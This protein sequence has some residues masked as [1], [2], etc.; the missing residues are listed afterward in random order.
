MPAGQKV[1][2]AYIEVRPYLNDQ[3]FRQ[4]V[5]KS[6]DRSEKAWEASA[7][8]M[9]E[10]LT[11]EYNKAAGKMVD[12]NK[13]ALNKIDR[14]I[15]QHNAKQIS[16]NKSVLDKQERNHEASLSRRLKLERAA[17]NQVDRIRARKTSPLT[18]GKDKDR[19]PRPGS[20]A[21]AAAKSFTGGL[22]QNLLSIMPGQLEKIFASPK[23]AAV[24]VT[25]A[26]VIGAVLTDGLV[27]AIGAGMVTAGV[28]GAA[29]FL[30]KTNPAF[31][32]A[33]NAIGE[34]FVTTLKAKLDSL[35]PLLAGVM[36]SGGKAINSIIAS[37]DLGP[38]E[39]VA[40]QFSEFFQQASPVV[41]DLVNTF[42]QLGE[43]VMPTIL[44]GTMDLLGAFQTL[45]T[46][47]M[48][49][50]DAIKAVVDG[51]FDMVEGVVYVASALVELTGVLKTAV[52]WAGKLDLKNLMP[53]DVREQIYGAKDALP[54]AND[55]SN[56][57]NFGNNAR[58]ALEGSGVA[59]L[60]AAGA[61]NDY[62]AAIK[63]SEDNL[64]SL[65]DSIDTYNDK[66]LAAM[67]ADLAWSDN[68]DRLKEALKRSGGAISLKDTKTKAARKS[69]VEGIRLADEAAKKTLEETHSVDAA[70]KTYR[71]KVEN[72]IKT[73]G[74]SKETAKQI[75]IMADKLL[76][77][78]NTPATPKTPKVNA[79]PAKTA[80]TSLEA[81]LRAIT[82]DRVVNVVVNTS[83]RSMGGG[84][85]TAEEKAAQREPAVKPKKIATGGLVL[86][87][88]TGKSDSIP[89]MLSN[90][91]FVIQSD[92]VKKIGVDQLRALNEGKVLHRA[93]GGT[94]GKVSAKA[95]NARMGR[96][97]QAFSVQLQILNKAITR[98]TAI[99][100]KYLEKLRDIQGS[101]DQFTNLGALETEG[102]TPTDILKELIGRRKTEEAFTN[103]VIALKKR[104]LGAEGV[105]QLLEAGPDSPL[106]KMMSRFSAYDIGLVNRTLG[107]SATAKRLAQAV[108][109]G[110]A[111]NAKSLAANQKQAK[112]V[113]A[114]MIA[115]QKQ[116]A[117][118]FAPKATGTRT[119][120]FSKQEL[121]NLGMKSGQVIKVIIDGKEVRA[122]VREENTKAGMKASTAIRRG[123]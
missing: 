86:G 11:S 10:R 106:A 65:Q 90:G 42:L 101:F 116:G 63:A 19:G 89:A 78:N 64:K 37:I 117:A 71:A 95:A 51:L 27:A 110:A 75:R 70:N 16:A 84:T 119:V 8:K 83:Q 68:Q 92:A 121:A 113:Q 25:G 23:M 43:E 13:D 6:I 111:Q 114:K 81:Q 29:V 41:G 45:A 57:Q 74:A 104:G 12:A 54:D 35:A 30:A 14:Q 32:Q 91:E 34:T 21:R 56:I 48:E 60:G 47:A 33:A 73:S 9:S 72:L 77:W 99:Q 118:K 102:K 20:L 61:Q 97:F 2:D 105:Q 108:M 123:R 96:E 88:G 62:A 7:K 26:A 107:D 120:L 87:P 5:Q 100:E 3:R 18:G 82:K 66:A 58:A 98:Q 4:Q 109:P 22:A 93:R 67:D 31:A 80:L 28:V 38:I 79:G 15:G 85:L 103:A 69:V 76:G 49:N 53:D 1:G 59:A 55:A 39:T 17:A 40:A 24:G 94:A 122:I 52:D 44:S 46:T 36:E 115:L 50:K 112:A